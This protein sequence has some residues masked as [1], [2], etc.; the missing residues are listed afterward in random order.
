MNVN[1]VNNENNKKSHDALAYLN[2]LLYL[3]TLIHISAIAL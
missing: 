1:Y 2:F 3:C